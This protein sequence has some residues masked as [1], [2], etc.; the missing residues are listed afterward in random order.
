LADQL[1]GRWIGT[2]LKPVTLSQHCPRSPANR[3]EDFIEQPLNLAVSC[4]LLKPSVPR[5][6]FRFRVTKILQEHIQ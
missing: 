2:L 5:Y 6:A 1:Q 4:C 3:T